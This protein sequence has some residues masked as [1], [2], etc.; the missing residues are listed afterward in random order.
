MA[1]S[2]KSKLRMSNVSRRSA[3][4][5]SLV[6]GPV[7]VVVLVIVWRVWFSDPGPLSVDVDSPVAIG[8][9]GDV[10]EVD[11]S[12]D[13][14]RPVGGELQS[15]PKAG[16]ATQAGVVDAVQSAGD[17]PADWLARPRAR[18]PLGKLFA[19]APLGVE[20]D[21]LVRHVVLNPTDQV[22]DRATLDS[23]EALMDRHQAAIDAGFKEYGLKRHAILKSLDKRGELSEVT[24]NSLKDPAHRKEAKLSV[25]RRLIAAGDTSPTARKLAEWQVLHSRSPDVKPGMSAFLIKQGRLLVATRE[26]LSELDVHTSHYEYLRSAFLYETLAWFIA[27]GL[28]EQSSVVSVVA[29]F[30]SF[31]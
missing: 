16:G 7:C 14:E 13:T 23:L 25:Q 26:Q 2:V 28:T 30:N 15:R 21:Y 22:L 29:E 19:L 20:V 10:D 6:V 5:A 8:S 27:S 4:R 11:L 9:S 3:G 1:S 12:Q 17:V 31:L 24:L 18:R